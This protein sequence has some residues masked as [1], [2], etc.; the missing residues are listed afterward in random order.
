MTVSHLTDEQLAEQL[1][2]NASHASEAHLAA[3]AACREEIIRMRESLRIFNYASLEWGQHT[4]GARRP[5]PSWRPVLALAAI[6]IAV[7][8]A[9]LLVGLLRRPQPVR[10]AASPAGDHNTAELSQDNKL[11]SAIDQELD[12]TGLSP[13]KMYGVPGSAKTQ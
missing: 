6:C 9:I 10:L 8:S 2:G 3:C 5:A 11:L 12:S 4:S 13:Q 1:A 7:I